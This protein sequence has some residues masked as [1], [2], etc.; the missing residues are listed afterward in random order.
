MSFLHKMASDPL[1]ESKIIE[2]FKIQG[3]PDNLSPEELLRK[4]MDE[5]AEKV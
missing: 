2:S 4:E 3:S 5:Y 1:A